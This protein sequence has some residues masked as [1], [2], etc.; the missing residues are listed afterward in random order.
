M[1]ERVAGEEGGRLAARLAVV[2]AAVC[3]ST[4]GVA[5]KATEFGGGAVAGLRSGVAALVLLALLPSARRAFG[6]GADGRTWLVACAYAATMILFVAANKRTTAAH[7]VFLQSTAPF[8]VLLLGAVFLRERARARDGAFLV[9]LGLGAWLIF[10]GRAPVSATSPDPDA[11]N[12]LGLAAGGSWALTLIGLRGLAAR[13][14]PVA[15]VAAGNALTFAV[16]LPWIVPALP[17][18]GAGDA[19]A[20]GWL[21]AVQIGLAYVFLTRGMP[22]V[23]AFE[24]SVL[25][26]LE[27]A[28]APL[29]ALV[30]LGEL[31]GPLVFAG[32][33][34]I[35]ASSV[36]KSLLELRSGR[37][38]G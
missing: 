13:A 23:S 14:V 35:V 22:R 11:G 8:Y 28:L 17:G 21:G 32:G 29:W 2:A 36:A 10:V 9:A 15:A 20:L 30:L 34:V 33:A 4:G 16:A 31:P 26:T 12:L 5:I 1:A 37:A 18:M 27:P 38:A 25:L 24:A 3:F 19:L 7:A 6:R